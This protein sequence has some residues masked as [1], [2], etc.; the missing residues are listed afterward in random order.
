MIS[1]GFQ[2]G[3]SQFEKKIRQSSPVSFHRFCNLKMVCKNILFHVDKIVLVAYAEQ[4][5]PRGKATVCCILP[6]D[7]V[8]MHL[9]DH[10]PSTHLQRPDIKHFI[11]PL[12][13]E[14]NV[15][16]LPPILAIVRQQ[17]ARVDA[18]TLT[19]MARVTASSDL[20]KRPRCVVPFAIVVSISKHFQYRY[21][22]IYR[23][24][25]LIQKIANSALNSMKM[26]V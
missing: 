6:R 2:N 8:W 15:T 23:Y 18:R 26:K 5:L 12:K 7:I 24:F 25:F 21:V 19:K 1:K 17:R 4:L 13:S 20:T 10:T 3:I 9:N 14:C 22:S 11:R 16:I